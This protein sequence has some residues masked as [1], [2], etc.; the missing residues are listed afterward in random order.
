MME[1]LADKIIKANREEERQEEREQLR[2]AVERVAIPRSKKIEYYIDDMGYRVEKDI[3]KDKVKFARYVY[4]RCMRRNKRLYYSF[5]DNN[6][7]NGH[8][9]IM[10]SIKDILLLANIT[11]SITEAQAVWVYNELKHN[12]PVLDSDRLRIAPG[13]IWRFSKARLEFDDEEIYKEDRR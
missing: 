9:A 11:D 4:R 13:L 7:H 3:Q 1:D 12:A 5:Y 10:P 8:T 6:L 2:E